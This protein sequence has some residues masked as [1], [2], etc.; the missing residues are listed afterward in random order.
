MQAGKLGKWTPALIAGGVFASVVAVTLVAGGNDDAAG[1]S[2]S[3]PAVVSSDTSLPA[4]TSTVPAFTTTTLPFT[5]LT[6]TLAL[7]NTG[8]SVKNLQ[9]RLKDL[10]FDPGPIDGQY[11]KATQSAVWAFEKLV[12]GVPRDDATGQVTPEMWQ[13]MHQPVEVL[14][15]RSTSDQTTSNHLEVYLEPQ[16]AVLFNDNQ[17]ILITHVSTGSGEEWE[18]EITIDPGTPDNET[19]EPITKRLA[20]TSKTPGGVYYFNRRYVEGDGWRTGSLGRMYKP[21][22]FNYGVAVHGSSNVPNEPASHGCVRIPMHISEYFP[23]LV[24]YGDTVYI[25][26]G[27]HDPEYY[28]SPPP[29]FD[30]D[31]TP[32][33]TTVA[34]TTTTTP[35]STSVGATTT[36][37]AKTT[38]T[39]AKTTTTVAP[40]TTAAPTTTVAPSTTQQA[41]ENPGG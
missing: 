19:D 16:V 21:V 5:E 30:R 23:D 10:H 32:T 14:P 24:K 17:P 12:L 34:P 39:V 4:T 31:I 26:D 7:G 29:P 37:V 25:F 27:V 3:T 2:T 6:K 15:K 11:G 18:E 41:V 40:T 38:T 20:G 22:Y 36:T 8:D 33:T 13:R 28:G 35:S 9:Q 1:S